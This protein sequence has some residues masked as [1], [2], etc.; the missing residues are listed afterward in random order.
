MTRASEE[1]VRR[2]IRPRPLA[3]GEMDVLDA[4]GFYAWWI[5]YNHRTDT[6]PQVP[7]VHPDGDK[8]WSLL[9]V[10]IAPKTSEQRTHRSLS[11]RIAKDHRRG[12][13]GSSTFRQSLAALL[14]PSM[15]GLRPKRGHDRSRLI[16]E[17]PLSDWISTRCG[18]T[19]AVTERPW[20]W[21]RAVICELQP[22]LNL[23]PGFH[24]FRLTVD[25]ARKALRKAC[26][27]Y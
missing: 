7:A 3:P 9:Y 27:L 24:P 14:I 4:P 12:N 22:P 2:L 25:E 19:I 23:K 11:V 6:R 8:E 20:L 15:P 1:I 18:L 16:D 21:E 5:R 26:G 10:G 17:R 13:I